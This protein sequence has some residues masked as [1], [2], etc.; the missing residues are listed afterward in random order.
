MSYVPIG[1]TESGQM[2]SD[3]MVITID[4]TPPEITSGDTAAEIQENS[5]A[6][7]IIYTATSKDES[8]VRYTLKD[9]DHFTIG[10][11]NGE[12]TLTENPDFENQSAYSFTVVATDDAG[13]ESLEQ[14]VNLS[15]ADQHLSAPQ[16]IDESDARIDSDGITNDLRQPSQVRPRQIAQLRFCLMDWLLDPLL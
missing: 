2:I 14:L 9:G 16:L 15:I 1:G 8:A 3:E 12:V 5:G 13:N 6:Y 10:S 11:R 7:Q 4:I